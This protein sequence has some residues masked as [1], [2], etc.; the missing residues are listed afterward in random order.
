MIESRKLALA[1]FWVAISAFAIA[2]G[3]A[4]MQ[5]LSR[6]NLDLP[7]RTA[8][9]YYLSVTA[10]GVLMALI[11]TT[12]FIMGFGY[13][14]AERA[15]GRP[16][17]QRKL[18]WGSFYVALLGTVLVAWAILWNK[19]TVLYTFYPPL[20]AHPAFY[21]GAALLV[22]GS[23][24]WCW[25]MVRSYILWK[26]ANPEARTPL[27][28]HG[29]LATIIVWILATVGVAAEVVLLL[30]PWSLGITERIDPILA[31]ILFWW[32]GH[33]LVYFW[34]LPAYVIWYTVTPRVAG[35]KLFSDPLAR[36]VFVLFIVLSTPV[37]FHHQFLDPGVRAGWKLFHAFNTQW[38]LFPSLLTAFTVIAS[39][40]IAGRLK[41][42]RGY[43]DWLE[44]LPW[45]DPA[46]SSVALAMIIFAVG[47][48]GGAINASYGMNAMI[49]NTAWV[50]GHFHLTVG[51]ATALTFM[52][53]A[54]WLMPKLLD[55]ELEL[56]LLAR[57][58]PYLWFGG[59]LLFSVANH[60]T[61]L[62]GMPRR[63]YQFDYG[64]SEVADQWMGGTGISAL[65]GVFLFVSALCFVA[66][67]F[68]T[69]LAGKRAPQADIEF[70]EPL[71]EPGSKARI[72]D[73]MGLWVVVAVA[74][75]AA[76]YAYPI[77]QH[78]A[79]ERFG[80]RGVPVF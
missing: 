43:L 67:M 14:V 62:K 1:N 39:F 7:W 42:A 75:V 74:L 30:I 32:F 34:L 16:I 25:V 13:V 69:G 4:V 76:A 9:M 3:M 64:G 59:M 61:G 2:A 44:E 56:S 71:E 27:P 24:G 48:F 29:Y 70:A 31:R 47:G 73:R 50:Q 51:T 49:H 18:A 68:G 8:K 52:G 63:I 23:W 6:A 20:K 41:G 28:V 60:L 40:E 80:A 21:I 79:T 55:R 66:V 65:G 53:A 72:L 77:I 33:P 22:I 45:G 58:Q 37:G 57:I 35:G 11:F 78:L 10:H 19:A 36:L 5:A 12:F 46:F 38:I 26:Q 15:L 17:A 54:Y